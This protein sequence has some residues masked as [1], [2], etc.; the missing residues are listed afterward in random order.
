MGARHRLTA[1]E[2]APEVLRLAPCVG[3]RRLRSSP[4]G[5]LALAAGVIA[6]IAAGLVLDVGAGPL[7]QALIGVATWLLLLAALVAR[8]P[9][10]AVAGRRRRRGSRRPR[11]SWPRWCWGCTSTGS[12]TCR[13]SCRRATASCTCRRSRSAARS[14]SPSCAARWCSRA[15]R[16]L[17]SGRSGASPSRRGPTCS[18][19]CVAV[20]LVAFLL[21]GRAPLVYAAAFVVTSYLELLGTALGTWAWVPHDPIT[22]LISM[23]NPPSGIAGAY[24]VLDATALVG[25]AWLGARLV[26]EAPAQ[27]GS[28]RRH[29]EPE[30]AQLLV[31]AARRARLAPLQTTA[32][33]L[34]VDA[35]RPWRCRARASTPGIVADSAN[36]TPSNVLWLSLSTI[37]CQGLSPRRRTG[38]PG[39]LAN[40]NLDRHPPIMPAAR[41]LHRWPRVR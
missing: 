19:R 25:G 21:R 12:A 41:T 40:G 31:V 28:K 30:A 2:R 34:R 18:A 23:G 15:S 9:H 22:G 33:P 39:A 4:V 32:L 20:M 16:A 38:A 5:D 11:R 8:D 24:C 35:C 13:P 27:P 7:R 36:A 1:D 14:C 10:R 29:R 6:W 3:D 37:T 17:G 26:S